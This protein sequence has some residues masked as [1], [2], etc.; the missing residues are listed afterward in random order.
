MEASGALIPVSFE[1]RVGSLALALTGMGRSR[2]S[3]SGISGG[4]ARTPRSGASY[5]T[6]R[7]SQSPA[8]RPPL[9]A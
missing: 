9:L 3:L 2:F 4:T 7:F 6:G 8:C 5:L 1:V